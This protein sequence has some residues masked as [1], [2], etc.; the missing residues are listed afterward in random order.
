MATALRQEGR[1]FKS[2]RTGCLRIGIDASCWVNKRGQGRYTRELVRALVSLD[3]RNHYRLFLDAE[4]IRQCEDVPQSERTQWVV[5]TTSQAAVR[6]AL[7]SGHRSLRDLWAMSH[8]VRQH[9]KE[10][11][12]FYFPSAT[13]VFPLM[14]R[15]KTVIT[16]HDTIPQHYPSLVFS[17]WHSRFF[18]RLKLR[19]AIGRADVIATVS[20]TAKRDIMRAFRLDETNV[21]VIPG[22]ANPLFHAL[23]DRSRSRQVVCEYGVDC[24]ERFI[25]YVGGLNP[26]KNLAGVIDAYA[27][28]I[29]RPGVEDVKLVIAGDF[30]TFPAYSNYRDL[31]A[32]VIELGLAREG[33]FYRLSL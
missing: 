26:H 23:S 5:V 20:Q 27:A 13:T 1:E 30:A 33:Y 15:A 16:I 19:Y 8:A 29:R 3:Q 14:T 22:A 10:L 12:L 6:G 11:D 18:W 25:L 28:L 9:G 17:H 31:R 7:V 4:T 32:K 24:H 2:A 21:K